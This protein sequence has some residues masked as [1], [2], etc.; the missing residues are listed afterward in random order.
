MYLIW[1]QPVVVSTNLN[2]SEY[3]GCGYQ[4]IGFKQNSPEG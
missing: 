1:R 2:L 4:L 3:S